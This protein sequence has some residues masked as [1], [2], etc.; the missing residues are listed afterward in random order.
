MVVRTADPTHAPWFPHGGPFRYTVDMSQYRRAF[1]PGGI[2]FFTVVTERRAPILANVDAV[3]LLRSAIE[4]TR[5]RFPFDVDAM[6]VLA[7]HLHAIWSLPES[8]SDYSTR[9]SYLK[10][11]F[12]KAWLSQGG[13]EQATTDSR[14][15]NRRRGV[16]QRRFWEHVIRDDADFARHCDYIHYNPVKHGVATCPHGWAYSSFQRCVQ[17]GLYERD[18]QCVC[19]GRAVDRLRFDDLAATAME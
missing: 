18:W 12:T 14:R 16:W 8:D 15:R 6:V 7:D 2:F 13:Q 9:W 11:T 10:R 3:T 1:V 5:E 19:D 4:R 17:V